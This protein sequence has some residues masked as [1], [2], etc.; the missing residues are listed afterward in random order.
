MP[1]TPSHAVVALPL[2][3]TPLIP[4]A[5]AVGAMTPDLPLFVRGTPFTYAISH[6]PAWIV[7]TSVVALALLLVWRSVLRPAVRE[8][9]PRR[10]ADG[11]PAAWDAGAAAGA[12]ETLVGERPGRHALLLALS[13]VIGAATHIAW[14]AFTHEGR[15]GTAWIPAL[16]AFWGPLTG[17]KWLQYG[18]SVLGLV[19]LAIVGAWWLIGRSHVAPVA[20]VL[21]DAVRW[22]WWLS[23]PVLLLAATA[24]G[25]AA[26]GPFDREFTPQHLAYRV[27]PPACAIW[28]V[29]T[30][31]LAVVVAVLRRDG[32]GRRDAQPSSPQPA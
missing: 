13:L 7:I 19:I 32:R 6:D 2:V 16:D 31:A 15:A 20:R 26:F 25:Y 9:A 12:R 28:G 5:I 1:F 18:S 14:D 3:R 21:P 29:V 27:L 23:L 4:A 17:Y 30:L 8:L 24:I 11:L 22:A 10:L